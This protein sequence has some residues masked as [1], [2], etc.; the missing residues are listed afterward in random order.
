M[1]KQIR[2]YQ[3]LH[4]SFRFSKSLEFFLRIDDIFDK[5]DEIFG[6]TDDNYW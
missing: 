6:K 1:C 3:R 4:Y 5:F 2:N